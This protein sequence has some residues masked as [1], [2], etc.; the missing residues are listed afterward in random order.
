M[1][2]ICGVSGSGRRAN[3]QSR[4]N[5]WQ[6]KIVVPRMIIMKRTWI[7]WWRDLRVRA[8]ERYIVKTVIRKR[9]DI[10]HA[11]HFDRAACPLTNEKQVPLSAFRRT[12]YPSLWLL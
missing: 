1:L 3:I 12:Q 9:P 7:S 8:R 11:M 4:I 2:G 6:K 10:R 5:E